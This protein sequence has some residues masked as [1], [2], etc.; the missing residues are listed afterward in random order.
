[1]RLIATT[2]YMR[3]C[4]RKHEIVTKSGRYSLALSGYLLKLSLRYNCVLGA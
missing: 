2:A 1:M 4:H 3:S